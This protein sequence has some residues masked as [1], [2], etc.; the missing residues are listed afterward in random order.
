MFFFV[1]ELRNLIYSTYK[2]SCFNIFVLFLSILVFSFVLNKLITK[3][4]NVCVRKENEKGTAYRLSELI[5]VCSC[6]S[7]HDVAFLGFL[8]GKNDETERWKRVKEEF[9]ICLHGYDISVFMPFFFLLFQCC[10]LSFSITQH[11]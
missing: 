10:S 7:V 9:L 1:K 5:G 3:W 2:W 4:M 6:D 8:F 11:E